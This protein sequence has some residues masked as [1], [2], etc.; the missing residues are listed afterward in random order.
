MHRVLVRR[1]SPA[2]VVA[3]VALFVALGG[4]AYATT[5]L[6]KNSVGPRQLKKNA[7][8]SPKVKDHSL[9]AKDFKSGQLPRGPRGPKGA[10][11]PRGPKGDTGQQGPKGDA[12]QQGP[13]ATTL[14]YDA[15][16][17]G[18]PSPTTVGTVLGDTFSA[19]CSIPSAGEA[20]LK[21]YV[22]TSDGSLRWDYGGE[23][24]DNG[25]SSTAANNVDLPAGTISSPQLVGSASAEA[26]GSKSNHNSQVV[27][28]GPEPGYLNV[29]ST[30]ETTTGP[31]T[32]K[33][34]LSILAF[35][36]G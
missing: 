2:M 13:G 6:P 16:A 3:L 21:V 14:T 4:A 17:S 25:T 27:Q 23:F 9:L 31:T 15:N 22:M 5:Q 19:E 11:G 36:A 1:P 20:E 30:A 35:P 12:G 24:T 26:G 8:T 32:E 10:N 18:S 34:H 33:C 29:H 7:V 28:L